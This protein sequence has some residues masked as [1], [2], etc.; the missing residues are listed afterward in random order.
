MEED[1]LNMYISLGVRNL[2][3]V[4]SLGKFSLLKYFHYNTH[5]MVQVYLRIMN[6]KSCTYTYIHIYVHMYLH[7]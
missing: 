7:I 6:H 3:T 1:Q 4:H 2:Y 5:N